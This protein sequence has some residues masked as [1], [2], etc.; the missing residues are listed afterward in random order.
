MKTDPYNR[1]HDIDWLRTLA[2]ATIFLFHCARFFDEEGW[3]V[4]N[5]EISF[6]MTVFVGV[7]AQWIMPLFFVLSAW[8]A[9]A[10][11]GR[12]SN[13]A[14]LGERFRRL[15]VPLVFGIFVI[16]PPQVYIEGV[17]GGRFTGSFFAFLPHYFDGFYGFGGN[18]AW[19]GLHLW[20]LEM[21]FLFSLITL[22][23][24]RRLGRARTPGRPSRLAAVTGRPGLVFTLAIPVAVVEALVN[25]QP[26]GFG[27]RDF[28][29][30]SPFTYLVFFVVGY[31]ISTD[32]GARPCL[33]RHRKVA[34]AAGVLATLG[35]Y[36]WITSGGSS[37]T[38][39]FSVLRAFNA[40][41]W[42]VAILGFG[43]RHLTFSNR[44]LKHAGEAVLPF[45]VLHQTVIV[46]VGYR[47]IPLDAGIPVTF[48]ILSTTSFMTIVALYELIVRRIPFLRFL[49][50]M[51]P[52]VR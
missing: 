42:L 31:L 10:A 24:F 41:S 40:W 48:L 28:G 11:L 8:S 45:Y 38:P 7:V 27:I 22:P 19:M 1:R 44:F 5:D 29:G 46:L 33:E 18:F 3:H 32:P 15:V 16:V 47:L 35:G 25:R 36:L 26:D 17:T 23:L 4:K 20:Y 6:T 34:L 30:W 13:G 50:G 37:Y 49:F 52:A 14:Y 21:L 39:A 43:S 9:K 2:M 51:K 12:R